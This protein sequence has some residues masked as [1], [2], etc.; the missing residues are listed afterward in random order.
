MD[1]NILILDRTTRL[2]DKL[3]LHIP[4]AGGARVM[5][6]LADSDSDIGGFA[7]WDIELA[8]LENLDD[9]YGKRIHIKPN[10]EAYPDDTLGTDILGA[11]TD[12]NYWSTRSDH[13]DDYSYG[14]ILVDFKRIKGRQYHVHVELTLTDSDEDPEDLSPEDFDVH[15]SADFTV[16]VDE[17]NPME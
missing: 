2:I 15:A 9:L 4:A 7:L 17:E 3:Q 14:D 13:L 12:G 11:M 1:D 16:T 6:L 5:Y 10:G 8:C